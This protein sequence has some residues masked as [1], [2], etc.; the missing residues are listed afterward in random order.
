MQD[1]LWGW[2]YS[3]SSDTRKEWQATSGGLL[4]IKGN[5]IQAKLRSMM[6]PTLW[7]CTGWCRRGGN[8]DNNSRGK[9]SSCYGPMLSLFFFVV[10]IEI[11]DQIMYILL[12][13]FNYVAGK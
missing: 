1:N 5:P 10:K 9:S 6:A 4:G 12:Q 8:A 11:E 13:T 3:Y 2:D 7:I